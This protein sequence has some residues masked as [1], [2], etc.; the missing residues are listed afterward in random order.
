MKQIIREEF[1][2]LMGSATP[3]SADFNQRSNQR[4]NQNFHS[5]GFRSRFGDAV[6]YNCGRKGHTYYFCRSKPE[7]RLPR[8]GVPGSR[9]NV[10][11]GIKV[12]LSGNLIRE[13]EERPCLVAK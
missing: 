4:N 10:I 13:T 7:P 8:R 1:Q 5:R 2:Q 11:K 12:A 9:Q 6:C 3:K